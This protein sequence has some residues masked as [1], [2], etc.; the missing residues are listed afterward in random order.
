[1]KINDV[2]E[3]ETWVVFVWYTQCNVCGIAVLVYYVIW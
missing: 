2:G 3:D 1:M